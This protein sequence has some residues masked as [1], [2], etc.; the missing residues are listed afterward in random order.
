MKRVI[1]TFF[2]HEKKTYKNYISGEDK[3]DSKPSSTEDSKKDG[4]PTP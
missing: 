4:G 2:I 3:E 1:K